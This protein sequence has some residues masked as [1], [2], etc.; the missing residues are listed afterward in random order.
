MGTPFV[1]ITSDKIMGSVKT[2]KDLSTNHC[3]AFDSGDRRPCGGLLHELENLYP[4]PD[5][6]GLRRRLCLCRSGRS[7][8]KG[9]EL[10][11]VQMEYRHPHLGD[12]T[13]LGQARQEHGDC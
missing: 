4:A 5:P 13:E 8:R 2:G 3:R 12:R 6:E 10:N 9:A 1:A 11:P 7:L